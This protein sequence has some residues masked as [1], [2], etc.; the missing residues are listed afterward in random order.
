M[1]QVLYDVPHASSR[2]VVNGYVEQGST[3]TPFDMQVRNGTSRYHLARQA[4]DALARTGVITPEAAREAGAR[5]DRVLADHRA[6]IVEH[7]VDPAFIAD[8]TWR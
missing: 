1:K 2:C 7:G 3:T 5:Y 8:W 6:Y 4:A